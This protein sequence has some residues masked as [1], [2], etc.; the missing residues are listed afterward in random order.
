MIRKFPV[1]TSWA[2]L[3][4]EF[5][6]DPPTICQRA[7]LPRKALSGVAPTLTGPEYMQL[8]RGL[9][10]LV[11][12]P[13]L[14]FWLGSLAGTHPFKPVAV[15]AR[16][17][18]TLDVALERMKRYKILMGPLGIQWTI[19]DNIIQIS[20]F[21]VDA[22]LCQLISHCEAAYWPAF[23][24][25]AL[26]PERPLAVETPSPPPGA[27][28][29]VGVA[30]RDSQSTA[31]HFSGELLTRPFATRDD[32]LWRFLEPVLEERLRVSDGAPVSTATKVRVSLF[33]RISVGETTV[34]ECA[35]LLGT[36]SRTLQRRLA[37]EGCSFAAL[38]Q[39]VRRWLATYF[40]RA[41]SLKAADIALLLGYG[42]ETSFY[43]ACRT[44]GIRSPHS[45]R[46]AAPQPSGAGGDASQ[47]MGT[48]ATHQHRCAHAPASKNA[49]Q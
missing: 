14:G 38:L 43:R 37:A 21:G 18:P 1:D 42:D 16:C 36:S 4:P 44:L 33:E 49:E 7:E 47:D 2:V 48:S 24:S 20:P 46:K 23:V 41:T 22:P 12:N 26:G 35:R 9:D 10:E 45:L 29:F 30:P 8:Y 34:G 6:F 32:D 25:Q 15:A 13:M 40:L 17:A 11:G 39:D 19:K 31:V 3:Y 5:A 27:E 28:P